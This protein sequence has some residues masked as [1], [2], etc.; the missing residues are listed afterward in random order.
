MNA[1]REATVLLTMAGKDIDLL[2]FIITSDLVADEIFGFHAQQAAEKTLKAWIIGAGGTI[3]RT[4]D[5]RRLLI[6]LQ[7]LGFNVDC[8]R[9]LI[10][11]NS[12]AVQFRYEAM[13]EEDVPLD[14][15]DTL[16]KVE[17]L[18]EYVKAF[19]TKA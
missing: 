11:L 2:R 6:M 13:E 19:L 18:H 8:Y 5:V 12:F 15:A 14:R 1:N 9:E 3:D 4:H 7:D 16:I 10:P 17:G